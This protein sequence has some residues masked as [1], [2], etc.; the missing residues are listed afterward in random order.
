M[1][2]CRIEKSGLGG[3][4]DGWVVGPDGAGTHQYQC[5]NAFFFLAAWYGMQDLSSVTRD[6]TCTPCLEA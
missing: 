5:L 1:E 4:T 3:E 6:R 2:R